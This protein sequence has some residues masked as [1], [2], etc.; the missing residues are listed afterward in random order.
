MTPARGSDYIRSRR[1]GLWVAPVGEVLK[2]IRVRNAAQFSNYSRSAT[3]IDFDAV[4]NL[5]TFQPQKV[6]GASLIPIVYDNPVTLKVHV[7]STDNVLGVQV[8]GTAVG[9]AIRT[10]AGQPVCCSL[11]LRLIPQGTWW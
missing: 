8:S 6:D 10:I 3:A 7:L 2:Y 9:F 11:I 1:D 5:A 4:H